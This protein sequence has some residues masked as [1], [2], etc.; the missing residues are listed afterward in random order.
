MESAGLADVAREFILFTPFAH[1]AFRQL[2]RALR[3]LPL[4][5]QY[6]CSGRVPAP[7]YLDQV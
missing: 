3:W 5:A 6:I 7:R 2:D 4:G 1:E